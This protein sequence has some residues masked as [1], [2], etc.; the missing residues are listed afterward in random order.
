MKIYLVRHGES[1]GNK[2][3]LCFGQTDYDL[4]ELGIIQAMEV[5]RK[6]ECI[7]FS[8]CYTSNLCRA[9]H[10]ATVN[11]TSHSVPLY[12]DAR[13]NEQ[14]MGK[15][16]NVNGETLAERYPIEFE[17]MLENWISNPPV[18]GEHFDEMYHRVQ[19]IA[20][21]ILDN[22]TDVLVVAHN[23]PLAMLVVYLLGLPPVAV[24]NFYFDYG[25]YSVIEIHP[26]G[27]RLSRLNV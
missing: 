25:K 2:K 17:A 12:K 21:V 18:D 11:L 20:E 4:T 19:E 8:T 3:Q 26:W 9:I 22:K 13:L 1:L 27:K 23:G 6:L 5:Q 7:P 15:F 16:E 14:Y 24:D 10:T